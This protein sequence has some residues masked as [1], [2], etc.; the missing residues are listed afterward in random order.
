[1]LC[2]TKSAFA[3]VA[4]ALFSIIPFQCG[5]NANI[6]GMDQTG[7]RTTPRIQAA[8]LHSTKHGLSIVVQL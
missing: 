4:A 3:T 1:M 5:I 7:S 2:M 8:F 6:D